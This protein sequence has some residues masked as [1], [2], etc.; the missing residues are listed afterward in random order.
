MSGE[1]GPRTSQ[2]PG[3]LAH[4][5]EVRTPQLGRP[6]LWPPP[7]SPLL[8]PHPAFVVTPLVCCVRA[9]CRENPTTSWRL[10]PGTWCEVGEIHPRA[11][12]SAAARLPLGCRL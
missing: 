8:R 11:V 10:A 4:S 6:P 3:R 5:R 1:E 2:G 9:F 12:C 7:A